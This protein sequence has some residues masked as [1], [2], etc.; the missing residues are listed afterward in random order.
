MALARGGDGTGPR[1]GWH[2]PAKGMALARSYSADD[3]GAPSSSDGSAPPTDD[4]DRASCRGSSSGSS[5][6]SSE[7]YAD[8]L[9]GAAVRSGAPPKASLG[10]FPPRSQV[11]AS[12][13]HISAAEASAR[14]ASALRAQRARLRRCDVVAAPSAP[15]QRVGARFSATQAVVR[16]RL[17]SAADEEEAGE[18]REAGYVRAGLCVCVCVCVCVCACVCVCV[19][20]CVCAYTHTHTYTHART[21]AR[22]ARMHIREVTREA[23]MRWRGAS[24]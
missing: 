7:A 22:A 20:V 6:A 11:T 19:R 10:L 2:W 17:L 5:S 14:R 15:A 21:H 3:G 13:A 16:A 1:Q 9:A 23:C 4:E 8:D 12:A 24:G 18:V